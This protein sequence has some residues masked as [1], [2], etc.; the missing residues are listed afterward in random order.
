MLDIAKH[1]E[2]R[3]EMV[4]YKPLYDVSPDSWAYGY[5]AIVRPLALWYEDV[6]YHGVTQRRF[7]EI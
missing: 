4:L 7:T 2:S 6:E 1:S 5:S 3:E